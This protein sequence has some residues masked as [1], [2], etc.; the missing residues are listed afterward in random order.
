MTT[1]K[2]GGV[3]DLLSALDVIR[4]LEVG[5]VKLE[6]QRLTS[7][8]RVISRKGSEKR[9]DL[10]YR[11]NEEVFLPDD[12]SSLNLAGMIAAQ[13]ALNYGLFC[14][15]LVFHG[16]FDRQDRR[17]IEAMTA[18][19]AREI[20]VKKFLQHNP[21]LRGPAAEL[22]TVRRKSYLRAR[23]SFPGAVE[24]ESGAAAAPTTGWAADLSK[25]AVLSS[26]GKDSLLSYGLLDEIGR[27]A[28]PI[29]I[30]ESGRHWFTALNAF[31]Q[32]NNDVPGT[33]RVW[34]NADRAFTWMLRQFEFIRPDFAAVRSDEYPVR[35]WT[36]AVFLFGALPLLRKRCISRLLIGNEF[37]TTRRM[38]F[39]GITHYDGLYDQSRYF[40]NAMTRY[41][42]AKGW[43][44]SQ[45]SVLRPLSELLIEKILVE[46]YPHLQKD[47]VSCHA[48]HVEGDRVLPC[49][50]CEKCRRIIGMLSAI[51]ANPGNCGYTPRQIEEG[52]GAF[53]VKSV[54]QESDCAEQVLHM[55]EQRGLPGPAEGQAGK[56][57]PRPEVL[58]LR[59]DRER[60]PM[61][62]IPVDLREPLYR[63]FLEHASG[64]VRRSG[65]V[66]LETDALD[67]QELRKPYPFERRGAG[68]SPSGGAAQ[69]PAPGEPNHILAELSWPAAQRR[70]REVDVALLPVG[71][72]EQHGPH[73]PLDVD[74][75]D[76]DYLA[77]RVAEACSAPR[78]LVLPL[79]SYGVSYHHDDFSGTLSIGPDTLSRLVYEIGMSAARN[80]ISKLVI[81]NGHGGNSPALHFAAQMINRDARI[82]TC[83][84]SGESSDHDLD[85]LTETPNDVHAGEV[86]TSTALATRP[87][88][89]DMSAAR[90][91]VPEFSSRFLDF[92]SKRSVGWYTRVAQISPKGV[93]GDP[94][95]A[96]AEKGRMMW[97]VM[98][99][100]LVEFV[101]DIR[102]LSLEEIYQRRY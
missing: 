35:L 31:R 22:P 56:A 55:L 60:S 75:W 97:D 81:I 91:F 71:A 50:H 24:P 79:V 15:E 84:D 93:L 8:Y 82:F 2:R 49:G 25:H 54:A 88:L 48:A 66:W 63:L 68:G 102:E 90:R 23:L 33:A 86:E 28:D 19:T 99:K 64:A 87:E 38:S 18:N 17:F 12:P 76:A 29:F 51:G 77:R 32:L 10:V 74:A 34:T 70:L 14:D 37:D 61:D 42:Q 67:P 47:Q 80:G 44:V 83:V 6:P 52:L 89:V 57:Q 41:F 58:K 36:V 16:L 73:L 11:Y 5:P 27:G 39:R 96:T 26:G 53:S 62:D 98:V 59:F 4:R 20:Y 43:G 1:N 65:R 21:F 13:V 69:K 7:P 72:I 40:D 92:T 85:K 101:E 3:R 46:R 95:K 9:F 94:T 100:N 78:P 45:F 30:N